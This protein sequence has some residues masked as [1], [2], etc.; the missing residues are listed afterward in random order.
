MGRKKPEQLYGPRAVVTTSEGRRIWISDPGGRCLH[1]FDLQDR[2]YKKIIR[3]GN[4]RLLSPAGLCAGPDETIFVSDTENASIYQLSARTGT[5]LRSLR[6]I[7]DLDRPAALSFDDNS[8][9]LFVVDV[10]AHNVKVL[11]PQGQLV[12]VIGRRGTEEGQFNFPCDIADDG[13]TIWIADTGNQRVQGLTHA[14]DPVAVLGRAGD[15]P[16]EMALPKALATDRAGNVYVVDARFENVQIFNRTGDLLL[17]I[18]EE[19]IG[20]GQ[21][22]LPSGIFI[23]SNNRVWICDTYNRRVQVFDVLD[24][25]SEG[26]Q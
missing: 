12:R 23:D 15:A 11:T 6:I 17:V 26:D 8:Q 9:E 13:T 3:V 22:W 20:P 2:S 24:D 16:G 21:F 4:D 18:G 5:L 25:T 19:G 14:G 7:D 1:L 10:A